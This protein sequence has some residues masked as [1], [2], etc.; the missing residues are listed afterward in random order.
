MAILAFD[1]HVIK[2]FLILMNRRAVRLF[3][4]LLCLAG[5]ESRAAGHPPNIVFIYADDLGYGDLGCFGNGEINTPNIDRMA[6]QGAKLTCFYA[7]PLCT[8]SRAALLTGC[9]PVSVGLAVGS[10]APV[11]LAADAHGLDPAETTIPEVLASRGYVTAMFGKWHLG[12][13]PVFLPTRHGFETFYGIPYSHDIHPANDSMQFPA[14]PM[15]DGE[16]VVK[17]D[18][19]AEEFTRL[20]TDKTIGFIRDNQ[21]RPFFVYLAHPMP[22]R[23]IHAAPEFADKLGKRPPEQ[24][25]PFPDTR[26]R[27]WLL[28]AAIEEMDHHVGRILG[29]LEELGLDDNTLV[30]FASDNGP[31]AGSS[32]FLRGSK[33]SVYEGGLRVPCVV[34]WPG[35]IPGGQSIDAITTVMD[36]LPTFSALAA[37]EVPGNIAGRDIFPLLENRTAE[38]PHEIFL[39][40]D[41]IA[42]RGARMG[43]WKLINGDLYHLEN[44]S[45]ETQDIAADHPEVVADIKQRMQ[46]SHK[47]LMA[48]KRPPGRVKHPVPLSSGNE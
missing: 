29:V 30:V 32:G 25:E 10:I 34:R 45:G 14:L 31:A 5:L 47:Q 21:D 42:L 26:K 1:F 13:Q 7:A 15:L 16:K 11:L 40:Y 24:F 48:A 44:D 4:V 9:Y 37:A 33:G 6:R 35:R 8:P 36:W 20:F 38:S 28:P 22:H 43:P 19:D 39:Y 41:G 27:D 17:I 23:P 2:A 18:P 12:D 3:L 46:E